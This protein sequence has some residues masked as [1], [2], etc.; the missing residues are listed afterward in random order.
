MLGCLGFFAAN[1]V[2]PRDDEVIIVVFFY[3]DDDDDDEEEDEEDGDSF[4][5]LIGMIDLFAGDARE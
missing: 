4:G 1:R 5:R 2:S 3:Y